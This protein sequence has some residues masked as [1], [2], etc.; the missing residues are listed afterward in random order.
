MSEL[1][2]FVLPAMLTDSA[3]EWEAC[4]AAMLTECD[5]TL[6]FFAFILFS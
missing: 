5:S 2:T 4:D 1:A 3:V 6:T